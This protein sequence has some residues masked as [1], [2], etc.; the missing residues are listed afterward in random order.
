M[1][2]L[3]SCNSALVA[4]VLW[5]G[6]LLIGCGGG[7][8]L[9]AAAVDQALSLPV[10]SVPVRAVEVVTDAH[11]IQAPPE[12]P[13]PEVLV[14][15]DF[16]D[17]DKALERWEPERTTRSSER[18]VDSVVGFDGS[19]G[20]RVGPA[21]LNRSSACIPAVARVRVP[22]H[23]RYQ[24]AARVLTKGLG[25]RGMRAGAG[26]EVVALG[27]DPEDPEVKSRKLTATRLR[28][29]SDGWQA[30]TLTVDAEKGTKVLDIKL[31]RCSGSGVGHAVFDDLT[32][33]RVPEQVAALDAPDVGR[34]HRAEP[35]P[36]VRR[37]KS[38]DDHRPGILT[39][40]PSK[41]A[42]RVDRSEDARLHVGLAVDN[43]TPPDVR[44]CFS[45]S[46]VGGGE[47]LK[48]CV[49]S[50]HDDRRKDG[51]G[52]IDVVVKLPAQSEPST[53]LFSADKEG[54]DPEA[55]A[56]G[57]W[58]NPRVVPKERTASIED[59]PDVVLFI[60]DTMRRD[61]AGFG[62]YGL[63]RTTP[64]LDAFAR[65]ALDFSEAT[66]PAG[67]TLSSGTSIITGRYPAEHGAGWRVRRQQQ[68]LK[69]KDVQKREARTL[70]F[71]RVADEVPTLAEEMR[72]AGYRTMMVAS[73]HFLSPD[74]GFGRGFDRHAQYGGSSVQGGIKASKVVETLLEREPI[75]EG[76][77][78]FLVVHFIDPHIPYRHRSPGKA[79]WDAP[80]GFEYETEKY[81]GVSVLKIPKMG[82]EEK[83]RPQDVLKLYD[84]DIAHA[85][86][87]FGRLLGKFLHRGAGILV[88]A[89]HGEEF[90]DHGHFE[91][92][93][94]VFQEL[95]HVPMLVRPPDSPAPAVID[96]PVAL[97]DVMP[98]I[99]QWAGAPIPEGVEGEAL[100]AE[101]PESERLVWMEHQYMGPDRTGYRVGDQ[102]VVFTHPVG[103]FDDR[104]NKRRNP[105]TNGKKQGDSSPSR[106]AYPIL[107][108]G[109]LYDLS[110]DRAELEPAELAAGSPLLEPIAARL[111][112]HLPG[113]HLRCERPPEAPAVIDITAERA[114]VRIAPLSWSD[115][116]DVTV[117][118]HRKSG[119]ITIAPDSDPKART[120]G[121][122]DLTPWI[123]LSA[124]E[125]GRIDLG[126]LPA[127]C[128]SWTVDLLG[129]H[130]DLDDESQKLLEELGYMGD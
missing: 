107:A 35:H 109:K 48:R 80:E 92:G 29:D 116:D 16:N 5:C 32:L 91:H 103:W 39:L 72:R 100:T 87:V 46:E 127:G 115:A 79:G 83:A 45:I 88:T 113:T 121:P 50:D 81:Q 36:L 96:R 56:I 2:V 73:N 93:H 10:N 78:L 6:G 40:A 105:L 82:K 106:V 3:Q 125:G 20:L 55:P 41:W 49:A 12:P 38:D 120:T 13:A 14:T 54:G 31:M 63:R 43:R 28:G 104:V 58:G 98:T 57:L 130:V 61:H 108:G 71:T 114:I 24:L 60:F 30:L 111:K 9:D 7:P 129:S 76:E 64:M 22:S 42:L 85:D 65:Q 68:Q 123:V 128:T 25:G 37:L 124:A 97:A 101:A 51:E 84:A 66:S 74:F 110:T 94:H 47:L 19:Q 86:G 75:G 52:W 77:P 118:D 23:G 70:D 27:G 89:D 117:P 15:F 62:G 1:R 95:V 99:L 122:L 33:S 119:Q 53:L 112:D 4:A 26:I 90:N 17:G 126:E 34:A 8:D 102:K 11:F 44:V 67:W 59:K 18:L 21:R 69:V